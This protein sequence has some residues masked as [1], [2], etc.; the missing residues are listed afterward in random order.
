MQRNYLL[1]AIVLG[2]FLCAGMV[3]VGQS[4]SSALLEMKALERTVTVKGLA[5][6]EVK[7]N[8]AIRVVAFLKESGFSDS[9]ITVSLPS[10]EDR[11]AQGYV[12]PNV[13]YRYSAKINLSVYTSQIDL[14]LSTRKQMINLVKEGIAIASQDYENR[15]EFLFTALND[16]KPTMVG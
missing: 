16:V 12:D 9:E 2:G 6:K 3:Y 13:R 4:A 11:Q 1:P 15:T 7:A 5:E 14:M 10:I 8:I